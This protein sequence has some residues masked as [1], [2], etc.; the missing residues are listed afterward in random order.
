MDVTIR[1]EGDELSELQEIVATINAEQPNAA[2]TESRY[3]E[4]IIVGHLRK[5]LQ[6]A[7]VAYARTKS[8]AELK[9]VFGAIREVRNGK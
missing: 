1:I 5:R 4:Q 6:D 9:Q 3:A 7:Y 2:M 8:A